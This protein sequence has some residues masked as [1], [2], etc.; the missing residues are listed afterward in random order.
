MLEEQYARSQASAYN[1]ETNIL[2]S[3]FSLATITAIDGA[4][5]SR[6]SISPR[7]KGHIGHIA[8]NHGQTECV[9]F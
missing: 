1:I 7:S 3:Q 4:T 8:Y 9:V 2:L 6:F 5:T